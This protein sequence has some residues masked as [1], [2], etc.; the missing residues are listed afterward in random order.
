MYLNSY[1]RNLNF[2]KVRDLMSSM[3]PLDLVLDLPM[4]TDQAQ[5]LLRTRLLRADAGDPVDD[6]L[7]LDLA[8]L[9][10]HMALTLEQLSQP[11]P[12]TVAACGHKVNPE[13]SGGLAWGCA[14]LPFFGKG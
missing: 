14:V 11:G 8:R 4:L 10:G 3:K 5:H 2:T 7:A 6:V 1:D 13:T 9:P 12:V